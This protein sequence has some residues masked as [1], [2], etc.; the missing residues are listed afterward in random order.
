[1]KRTMIPSVLKLGLFAGILCLPGFLLGQQGAAVVHPPTLGFAFYSGALWP[2][3]GVPGASLLGNSLYT[4]LDLADAVVSPD[5]NYAFLLTG[6]L[7]QLKLLHLVASGA[8]ASPIDGAMAAPDVIALSPRGDAAALYRASDRLLQVLTGL[9]DSP[10]ILREIPSAALGGILTSMAVADDGEAVLVAVADQ[11]L[12]IPSD[13]IPRPLPVD[14][15][16]S[17][18]AFRPRT[19][20]A[21]AANRLNNL[22]LILRATE[23]AEI[24]L[25]AS[26]EDGILDPLAVAFSLDGS[27]AFVANSGGNLIQFDFSGGPP[28]SLS[29]QCRI[30]GLHRLIG[31]SVFLLTDLSDGPILVF[32]GDAPQPRIVVVP[33]VSEGGL[34]DPR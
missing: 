16:V 5:Q 3:L 1:M 27:R 11:A 4:G 25:L 17:A 31:N 12:L 19:H 34:N 20:D 13:G 8:A 6:E 29:C 33:A 32:D 30:A 14:G 7:H 21:I 10:R 22:S 18:M 26:P 9:P 15:P 24:Q 2:I 23:D 28:Q